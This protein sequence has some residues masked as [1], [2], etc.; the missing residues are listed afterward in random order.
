MSLVQ[1]HGLLRFGRG[2]ARMRWLPLQR[3]A[4]RS[5]AA[6]LVSVL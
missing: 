2:R 6:L 5:R 3:R 4:T 1:R